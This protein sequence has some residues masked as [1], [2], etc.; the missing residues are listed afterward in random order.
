MEISDTEEIFLPPGGTITEIAAAAPPKNHKH[1]SQKDGGISP[2]GDIATVAM[3]NSV[4]LKKHE[5]P[6]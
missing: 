1:G 2:L 4:E 3:T 5:E 6:S